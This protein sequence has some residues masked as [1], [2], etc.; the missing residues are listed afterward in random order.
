MGQVF[1]PTADGDE[2][3]FA[4]GACLV[5][6]QEAMATVKA[7]I[8]SFFTNTKDGASVRL[9]YKKKGRPYPLYA[10]RTGKKIVVGTAEDYKKH[11]WGKVVAALDDMHDY[12][13]G[14]SNAQHRP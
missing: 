7:H 9:D 8:L 2:V 14:Q 10:R 3:E 1:D 12:S 11:G 5:V 6:S 13:K 4:F